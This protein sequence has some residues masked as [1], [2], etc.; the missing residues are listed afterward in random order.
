VRHVRILGLA[1]IAAFAL[2]ALAATPALAREKPLCKHNQKEYFTPRGEH[3]C[4]TEKEHLGWRLFADCPLHE[5]PVSAEFDETQGC[6][7]AVTRTKE[8]FT[9]AEEKATLEAEGRKDIPSEFTAGKVTVLLKNSITLR[10]GIEESESEIFQWLGARG[11]NTIEPIAE[12]AP[13]LTKDIDTAKLSQAELERYNYYA[14]VTKETNATATVELAG[15]PLNIY[16]NE[17]NLLDEQGVAF[18]FPV[19]VKLSNPFLGES[20][21][22]GSNAHPVFV[23]FTT[24]DS[25]ELRGKTG[26]LSGT[27]VGL[28]L[29]IRNDT[30]VSLPFS[31]PGAE[32]C[33]VEGGADEALD[34]A[35]GLPSSTGNT[36]VLDGT[37]LQTS[38]EAAEEGLSEE[39]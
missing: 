5:P 25:G 7:W 36:S 1:L 15:S 11:A 32:G 20:C 9:S 30:L 24:G 12:P 22:V 2:C 19:K 16:L 17:E 38:A 13:P 3:I 4:E 21:Y 31:V 34:A 14:H 8:Q 39:R 26:A 33:G 18:G 35:I 6:D 27:N 23:E 28:T 10:G 37:L 29:V